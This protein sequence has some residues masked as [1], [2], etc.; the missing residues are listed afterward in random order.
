M[1][2]EA[3]ARGDGLARDAVPERGRD[4]VG[5]GKARALLGEGARGGLA[6]VGERKREPA[7]VAPL[8]AVGGVTAISARSASRSDC[9][10]FIGMQAR[11]QSATRAAT[12]ARIGATPAPSRPSATRPDRPI[13]APGAESGASVTGAAGGASRYARA[14]RG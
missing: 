6:R 8:A 9:C 12:T 10:A 7:Q 11:D 3:A 14:R 2:D 13:P 5:R 4:L 1:E